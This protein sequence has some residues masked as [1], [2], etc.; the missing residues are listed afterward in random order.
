MAK[1]Q[2]K[3]QHY[4]PQCYLEAWIDPS[5]LRQEQLEPYV[6]LWDTH[7]RS[8]R[9]KSPRKVFWENNL[10]TRAKE[11]GERDLT[12]ETELGNLESEFVDVRR[13]TFDAG[14]LPNGDDCETIVAFA[15][16]ACTRTPN[17]RD[18]IV[19]ASQF[20]KTAFA[21]YD[22]HAADFGLE[23]RPIYVP[24]GDELLT[25]AEYEKFVQR[26]LPATIETAFQRDLPTL[27]GMQVVVLRT[28]DQLGFITTDQPCVLHDPTQRHKTPEYRSQGLLMPNLEILM[29][30]SP[31][32]CLLLHHTR[33]KRSAFARTIGRRA[34]GRINHR[35]QAYAP[36]TVV[37]RHKEWRSAW[38]ARS[39][40]HF[41]S[42]MHERFS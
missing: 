10:Y 18:R 1:Q 5:S 16:A 36:S 11:S 31:G 35:L 12:I 21:Y 17:L 15:L 20:A 25:R 41:E 29:P 23:D 39:A 22:R 37:T 26:P 19:E 7:G 42:A 24:V 28:D 34:L 6:W 27:L 9:N 30:L 2:H 38:L 3:K 13:R 33:D 8:A 14:L 4:V 40:A 32:H